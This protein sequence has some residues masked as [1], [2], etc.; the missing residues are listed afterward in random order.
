M[1]IQ[2]DFYGKIE[3]T[4]E[5]L[6]TIPDGLFG[7][8]KLRSYLPLQLSE[9]DDSMMLFQSTEQPEVAFVL[10]NP[11]HLDPKYRPELTTEELLA[12]NALDSGELSYYVICVTRDNYLENT[13][14]LKC[15]LAINPQTRQGLQV[16][17]ADERYGYRHNL[18][19]FPGITDP[20]N[21]NDRS[22]CNAGS[23][24]QEK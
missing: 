14:N 11:C 22:D 15:P 20:A 18:S 9:D 2:T 6:I 17:L 13:V 24:T 8:P 16:I 5:D 3:Y 12:L 4:A 1:I 10:I 19:S 7:F 23:Q 21:S